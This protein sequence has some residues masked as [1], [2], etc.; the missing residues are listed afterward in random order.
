[1]YG[2]GGRRVFG[3]QKLS[4]RAP[5]RW[6]SAKLLSIRPVQCQPVRSVGV[7]PINDALDAA[8]AL[9]HIVCNKVEPR[10]SRVLRGSTQGEC[11]LASAVLRAPHEP[12]CRRMLVSFSLSLL[13]CKCIDQVWRAPSSAC[14]HPLPWP[15]RRQPP[16][17]L[18]RCRPR[19]RIISEEGPASVAGSSFPEICAPV[20]DGDEL[21]PSG[22]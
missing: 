14:R 13:S 21:A 1:M 11:T 15:R 19:K 16:R 6:T 7:P 4:V 18:D 5:Q 2:I 10:R 20:G 12:L 8:R 9:L 17:P 22:P 3:D